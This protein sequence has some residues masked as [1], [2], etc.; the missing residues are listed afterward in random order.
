MKQWCPLYVFLYSYADEARYVFTYVRYTSCSLFLICGMTVG[1]MIV[2]QVL[3]SL[4]FICVSKAI[5]ISPV[6]GML[7]VDAKL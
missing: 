3:H 2:W 1:K 5:I 6:N 7:P 4:I